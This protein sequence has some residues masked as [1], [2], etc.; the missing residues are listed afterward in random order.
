[1]DYDLKVAR[2]E[3]DMRILKLQVNFPMHNMFLAILFCSQVVMV[4]CF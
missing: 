1:M 2:I 3:A 4:I